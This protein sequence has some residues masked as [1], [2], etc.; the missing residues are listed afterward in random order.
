MRVMGLDLSLNSTGVSFGK[1][2]L[3]KCITKTRIIAPKKTKD[4]MEKIYF[5]KDNLRIMIKHF[6]PKKIY[7]EDLSLGSRGRGMFS[8]AKLHGVILYIIDRMG[9][10]RVMLPPTTVKKEITGRGNAKK[11]LVL[12][13]LYKRFSLDIDNEDEADAAAVLLTGLIKEGKLNVKK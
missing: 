9:I 2:K 13:A 11:S 5:V 3:K 6:K 8:L 1:T 4:T 12:K 7:I 10:P